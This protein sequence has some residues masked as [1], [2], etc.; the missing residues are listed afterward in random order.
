[1]KN[2][3]PKQVNP[4]FGFVWQPFENTTIRGAAFRSLKRT[5]ISSQT[6]EPTQIAGFNQ[7]FDG[8]NGEDQRLYGLAIDQ[9][10]NSDSYIGAEA[11]IRDIIVRW[12]EEI[13]DIKL[14]QNMGR[15]YFYKMLSPRWVFAAP[16]SI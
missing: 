2:I 10:I 5:V 16:I 7:F 6:I 12:D 14:R 4:K 3:N 1:M 9:K 8:I 15:V 13:G 11:S